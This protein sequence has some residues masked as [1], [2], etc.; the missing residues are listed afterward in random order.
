MAHWHLAFHRTLVL[1]YGRLKF[2]LS[3]RNV[4]PAAGALPYPT[5]VPSVN[6]PIRLF[7]L[8]CRRIS[9]LPEQRLGLVVMVICHSIQSFGGMSLRDNLRAPIAIPDA[10]RRLD[11][12]IVMRYIV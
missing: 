6:V 3:N 5:F 1:E 7:R 4:R 8:A 9:S 2:H 12:V 10:S 11:I